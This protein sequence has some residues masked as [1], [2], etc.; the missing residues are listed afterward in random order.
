MKLNKKQINYM[1]YQLMIIFSYY[2][3]KNM[4]ISLN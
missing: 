1:N 3:I 2:T 4:D